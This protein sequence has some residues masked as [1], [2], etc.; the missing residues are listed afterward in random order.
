VPELVGWRRS[1]RL[2]MNELMISLTFLLSRVHSHEFFN[3]ER[4]QQ[5]HT[6]YEILGVNI[7]KKKPSV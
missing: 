7:K 1:M 2:L 5:A 4:S 3:H 6:K